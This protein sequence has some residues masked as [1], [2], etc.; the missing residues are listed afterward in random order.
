MRRASES[1]RGQDLHAMLCHLRGAIPRA[2]AA[3]GFHLETCGF[4]GAPRFHRLLSITHRWCVARLERPSLGHRHALHVPSG[5]RI[6]IRWTSAARIPP[7]PAATDTH[8]NKQTHAKPPLQTPDGLDYVGMQPVA[9]E[10]PHHH[11][12]SNL[13]FYTLADLTRLSNLR[14]GQQWHSRVR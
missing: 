9:E 6:R 3:S 5:S 4:P 11:S 12:P 1:R 14:Y 13:S 2:G 8:Y 10:E 7:A